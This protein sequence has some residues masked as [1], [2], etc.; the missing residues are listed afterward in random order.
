MGRAW[1]PG[2]GH[3]WPSGDKGPEPG[4]VPAGP[5]GRTGN[6]LAVFLPGLETRG[7]RDRQVASVNSVCQACTE[8]PITGGEHA[9]FLIRFPLASDPR[10]WFCG[11][12]RKVSG[13]S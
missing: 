13:H 7:G 2:L 10:L 3:E 11:D 1:G 5:P 6:V 9:T 4:K 8:F 12:P